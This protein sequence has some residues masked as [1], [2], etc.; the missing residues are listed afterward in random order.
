MNSSKDS[1]E[2]FDRV[3]EGFDLSVNKEELLYSN[4]DNKENS[5]ESKQ[6]NDDKNGEAPDLNIYYEDIKKK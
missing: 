3:S 1:N 4:G 5:I 6:N 2:K